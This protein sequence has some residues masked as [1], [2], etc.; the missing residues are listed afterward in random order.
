MHSV[1][2]EQLRETPERASLQEVIGRM[3][4]VEPEFMTLVG[5]CS[6]LVVSAGMVTWLI[7]GSWTLGG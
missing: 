7:A 6:I 2:E 1:Q 3:Q 5:Q 4:S